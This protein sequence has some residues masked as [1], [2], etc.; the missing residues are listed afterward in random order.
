MPFKNV[1]PVYYVWTA[2]KDRCYNR[3]NRQYPDYGGRGIVVCDRWLSSYHDFAAD[4][5]ER[6]QNHSIDRID[7]DGNYE[8][9]NCRWADKS[10][11]QR[12]RRVAVFVEI[13]GQTYRA[14]EL[15]ERFGLKTDTIVARAAKG[16]T[17]ADVTFKGKHMNISGFAKGGRASG[18]KKLSRT[19]CSKGHEYTEENTHWRTDGARQCR[20]CHNAKMVRLNQLKRS[21]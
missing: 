18:D 7:N 8:P 19:H 15:A 12:N 4:M 20:I 6:P 17:Y 11:Q 14:I 9:G 13:E 10:T 5:G 2:M 1:P 3:N 21:S 16:M